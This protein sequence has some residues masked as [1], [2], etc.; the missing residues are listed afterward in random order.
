MPWGGYNFE[1]AILVSER[2]IKDDVFTS[3]HIEEFELQ[4]RDTKRGVEEITA[5]SPARRGSGRTS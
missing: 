5:R 4:V 3:I 2:L 1:D